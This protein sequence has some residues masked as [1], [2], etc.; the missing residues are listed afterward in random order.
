MAILIVFFRFGSRQRREILACCS[1]M[2]GHWKSIASRQGGDFVKT[3]QC[4]SMVV[5]V[6]HARKVIKGA[7]VLDDVTMELTGG[8]IYGL[9]GP[10]GS[11]KTMLMRAICGLIRLSGGQIQVDGRQLGKNLAVPQTTGALIESPAFL[12]QYTATGNLRLLAAIRGTASESDIRQTLLD[13]GL[14]P[15]DRRTFR[16]FSLGMK[17]RLGI[18]AA[19]VEW[20]RLVVVDEPTNGLDV[21]G[22]QQLRDLLIRHRD[23]G[24]L[25]LLASHDR[26]EMDFL[27]DEIF[28][29]SGGRLVTHRD[30][31]EAISEPRR[32]AE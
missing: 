1:V 5:H 26:A 6:S 18:A 21:D 22:V 3:A 2:T 16:K 23:S 14:D 31:D 11:G 10:N 8:K 30:R 7:V 32:R 25:V 15:H 29:M 19:L 4:P 20:P 28:E 24:A 27:A 12:S 13:V 9:R 17:Q